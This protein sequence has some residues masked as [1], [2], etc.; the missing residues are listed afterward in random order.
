VG[1]GFESGGFLHHCDS[2]DEIIPT[3]STSIPRSTERILP[4]TA[5]QIVPPAQLIAYQ[6]HNVIVMN[7]IYRGEIAA[8]LESNESRGESLLV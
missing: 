2:I 1:L 3:S 6:P 8:D 5:Q 4:G 7:P